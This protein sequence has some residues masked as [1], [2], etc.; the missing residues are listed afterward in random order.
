MTADQLERINRAAEKTIS[1]LDQI[2][3]AAD[4][5]ATSLDRLADMQAKVN[6]RRI[7][8]P[9]ADVLAMMSKA[10]RDGFRK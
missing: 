8:D 7:A 2:T 3:T 1:L 5:A 10:F 4:K 6:A 9:S